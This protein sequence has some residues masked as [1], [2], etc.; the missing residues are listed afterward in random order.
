MKMWTVIRTEKC[1][2]EEEE[3]VVCK[4]G[5]N[6]N[7]DNKVDIDSGEQK[8]SSP[9]NVVNSESKGNESHQSGGLKEM[10]TS[11]KKNIEDEVKEMEDN[12]EHE[13][14]TDKDDGKFNATHDI[15][16][17]NSDDNG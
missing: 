15:I 2:E 9:N 17:S 1:E 7:E 13:N 4:K 3:A 11:D 8:P 10:A 16:H 12:E 5:V 6:K 14:D